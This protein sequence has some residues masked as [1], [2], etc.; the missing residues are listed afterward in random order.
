MSIRLKERA[1]I[2][3][4]QH[5]E[6]IVSFVQ[7][8]IEN[9]IALNYNLWKTFHP[10]LDISVKQKPTLMIVIDLICPKN[11]SN[12]LSLSYELYHQNGNIYRIKL[13]NKIEPL[14][15]T[16]MR[17]TN[18]KYYYKMLKS[19]DLINKIDSV[20]RTNNFI[21]YLNNNLQYYLNTEGTIHYYNNIIVPLMQNDEKV[22]V[23]N[24]N[25]KAIYDITKD[26]YRQ[27]SSKYILVNPSNNSSKK[28]NLLIK[29]QSIEDSQFQYPN[30]KSKPLNKRIPKK[31]PVISDNPIK[32]LDI[33]S[34][35]KMIKS[36]GI[37]IYVLQSPKFE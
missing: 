36:N 18:D 26:Y 34:V 15:S 32:N 31:Q 37:E 12:I 3:I 33:E 5:S 25:S 35:K 2:N 1:P 14:N 6:A 24:R 8:Y 7:T 21:T 30:N 9:N 13:V 11:N 10:I 27:H 29:K 19:N 20:I 16:F 23:M 4:N 22:N 17:L 28:S